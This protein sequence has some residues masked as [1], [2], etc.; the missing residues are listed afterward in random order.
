MTTYGN[1]TGTNGNASN[2]TFVVDDGATH[3]L[4]NKAA[5]KFL[6]NSKEVYYKMNVA[7]EGETVIANWEGT[8]KLETEDVKKVNIK[9]F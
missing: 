1:N 8:L 4:I 2:I 3:H 6:I 9:I 5:R 7:K